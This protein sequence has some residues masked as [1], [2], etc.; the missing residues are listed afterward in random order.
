V[1][2]LQGIGQYQIDGTCDG[3]SIVSCGQWHMIVVATSTNEV[4]GWGWNKYGQLGP[5]I[6]DE[7][8]NNDDDNDD[9]CGSHHVDHRY[10]H[11][12]DHR[13]SKSRKRRR[14][15]YNNNNNNNN[16]DSNRSTKFISRDDYIHRDEIIPRPRCLTTMVKKNIHQY[17]KS[18]RYEKLDHDD[19]D[20][21][22]RKQGD[23]RSDDDDD[24]DHYCHD[25]DGDS[26]EYSIYEVLCGSDYTAIVYHSHGS[27]SSSIIIM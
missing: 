1:Q 10:Q 13:Y 21:E 11:Y 4:Y 15:S 24:D 3:A 6:E 2:D 5:N 12:T 16:S 22:L 20:I 25:D 27:I 23:H 19:D 17:N 8:G 14:D 26:V 7:G 18:K 9:S